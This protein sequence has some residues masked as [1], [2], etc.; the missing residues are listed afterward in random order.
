M[1]LQE[2]SERRDRIVRMWLTGRFKTYAALAEK[3]GVT[4]SYVCSIVSK[5]DADERDT[6]LAWDGKT[7]EMT[8]FRC[9]CMLLL[10]CATHSPGADK[11]SVMCSNAGLA[12]D[13]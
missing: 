1:T 12:V 8:L 10:P 3:C 13:E 6:R 9:K 7:I 2:S 5:L 11:F 4:K